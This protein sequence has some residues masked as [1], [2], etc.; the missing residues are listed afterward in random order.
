MYDFLSLRTKKACNSQKNCKETGK[1]TISSP[2]AFTFPVLL[3][4]CTT[5]VIFTCRQF[6]TL[7]S[8]VEG[9]VTWTSQG[10]GSI[11]VTYPNGHAKRSQWANHH[12][13]LLVHPIA[14]DIPAHRIETPPVYAKVWHLGRGATSWWSYFWI[15]TEVAVGCRATECSWQ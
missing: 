4:A 1:D 8:S 6:D 2:S 11:Q 5:C 7:Q 15:A 3:H 12:E 10:R 14:R 13:S 9:L